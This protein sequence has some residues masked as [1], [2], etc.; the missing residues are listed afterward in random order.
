MAKILLFAKTRESSDKS[1]VRKFRDFRENFAIFSQIRK[2]FPIL[3][4]DSAVWATP[5]SLIQKCGPHRGV[6]DHT[7]ESLTTPRSHSKWH[8]LA[9]K[10]TIRQKNDHLGIVQT[11][12]FKNQLT[13]IP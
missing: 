8:A 6:V 1:W 12:A 9:F 13:K 7:A 3:Q 5:R 10:W 11:K 4:N 2:T